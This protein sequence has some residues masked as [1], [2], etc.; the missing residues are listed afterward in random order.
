MN[1]TKPRDRELPFR[2]D[3]EEHRFEL[4]VHLVHLVDQK[5]ARFRRVL[6]RAHDWALNE[7][8][9]GME[10]APNEL[11]IRAELVRLC[12]EE[13]LLQGGIEFSNGLLFVNPRIALKS[14]HHRVKS[15]CQ[16]FRK[17]RLATT[18]GPSIRTGFFSSPATY[19]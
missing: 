18:G 10:P 17:F 15:R 5:D 8:V 16:G 9:Q 1:G 13:E 14:F 2:E 6:Q 3:F 11:P 12:F 4:L 7:E 19:T